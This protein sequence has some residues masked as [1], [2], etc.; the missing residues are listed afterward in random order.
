MRLWKER[1]M[2][3]AGQLKDDSFEQQGGQSR[4]VTEPRAHLT[5]TC[6]QK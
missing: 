2:W 6:L 3:E 4:H 5:R 1:P